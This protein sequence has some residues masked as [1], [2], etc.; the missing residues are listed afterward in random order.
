MVH[1]FNRFPIFAACA[2]SICLLL[3][4][5]AAMATTACPSG[6]YGGSTNSGTGY[7]PQY[8]PQNYG[9]TTGSITCTTGDLTYSEF[10]WTGVPSGY[11]PNNVTVTPLTTPGDEGFAFNPG[12]T[13]TGSGTTNNEDGTIAFE[14]TAAPG[15]VIN[16]LYIGFN[17]SYSNGGST[18][19]SEEYCTGGS[20]SAGL[21][22]CN[23]FEVTNPSGPVTDTINITPSTTLYI[24]KDFDATCI[25]AGSTCS[26]SIS[27]VQNNFSYVPE[28][29]Q[30]SWVAGG[31]F[32]LLLLGRKLRSLR[33]A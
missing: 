4:V 2:V 17:G 3:F 24:V 1:K 31:L 5:P 28:P 23:T 25:G 33:A 32:G 26:A 7:G 15:T 22:G 8:N 13:V 16:D 29:S 11:G 14:V 6:S 18:S 21:T 12:I 20:F 10:Q 30:V 9:V 27:L 19:F